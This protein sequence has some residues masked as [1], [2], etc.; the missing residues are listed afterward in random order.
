MI[1]F[2]LLS[3]S[4][5]ELARCK[6]FLVLGTHLGPMV[7]CLLLSNSFEGISQIQVR[8]SG[9]AGRL[10]ENTHFSMERVMRI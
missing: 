5:R 4:S 3:N 7:R 9:S 8:F 10:R 2:L 6:S 1:R